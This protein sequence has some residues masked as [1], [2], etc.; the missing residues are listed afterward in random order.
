M[1]RDRELDASAAAAGCCSG[2]D[3]RSAAAARADQW[4]DPVRVEG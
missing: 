2:T 1:R 4:D 3:I